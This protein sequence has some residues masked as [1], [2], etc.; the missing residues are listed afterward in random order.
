MILYGITDT[1]FRLQGLDAFGGN[2]SLDCLT[3]FRHLMV[4]VIV[5]SLHGIRLG[6]VRKWAS[7]VDDILSTAIHD[8]PMLGVIVSLAH[9]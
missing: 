5:N 3:M 2:V 6:A 1:F 9:V 8:F 4:D 7:G